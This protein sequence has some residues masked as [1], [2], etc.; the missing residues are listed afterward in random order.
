MSLQI[1]S[2]A[3]YSCLRQTSDGCGI[4]TVFPSCFLRNTQKGHPVLAEA[5]RAVRDGCQSNV[6]L[7]SVRLVSKTLII[8]FI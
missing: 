5:S 8:N 1:L 3:P 2:S 7:A 4:G 6:L